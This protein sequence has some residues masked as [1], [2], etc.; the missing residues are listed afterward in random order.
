MQRCIKCGYL[1]E[2][3]SRFCRCC[4]QKVIETTQIYSQP[5]E[6]LENPVWGILAL[7]SSIF[8]TGFLGLIFSIVGFVSYK[9]I[10]DSNHKANIGLSIAGLII[11]LLKFCAI[12]FML[13]F[14]FYRVIH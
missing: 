6:Q 4:G 8:L 7:L 3:N 2:P 9:Y 11:S 1:L 5:K 14:I 13:Y 12:A 10:E